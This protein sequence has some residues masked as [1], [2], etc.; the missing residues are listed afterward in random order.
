MAAL[1]FD[2]VVAGA[3]SN[4]STLA[5]AL[6]QAG[7]SVALVDPKPLDAGAA[8]NADGRAYFIAY[9]VLRQWRALGLGEALERDAQAVREI[10]VTDGPGPG[11]AAGAPA[12]VFLRFD[13]GDLG[14]AASPW[15]G[16]WRP[17]TSAPP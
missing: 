3:G 2:V 8:A 16:C 13:A 6:T 7:L 9:A 17:A 1:N 5:L 14:E 4:G 12:P 11:A 15:A 10:L